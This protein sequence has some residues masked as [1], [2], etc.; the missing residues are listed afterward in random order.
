[1]TVSFGFPAI[2]HPNET[3]I[4]HTRGQSMAQEMRLTVYVQPSGEFDARVEGTSRRTA[5]QVV[6]QRTP[7]MISGAFAQAEEQRR[8]R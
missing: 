3:V 4:D 7:Q 5:V 2:L 8:F 1:M 6:D